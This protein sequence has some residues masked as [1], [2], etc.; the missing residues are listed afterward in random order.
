MH[1][2][3]QLS[4][5][6][7]QKTPH[8]IGWI[9]DNVRIADSKVTSCLRILFTANVHYFCTKLRSNFGFKMENNAKL[10]NIRIFISF[11]IHRLI[12]LH[13]IIYAK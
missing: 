2:V 8:K 11:V 13:L 9:M 1:P 12:L 6:K 10:T 5:D 4:L 3:L 7:I